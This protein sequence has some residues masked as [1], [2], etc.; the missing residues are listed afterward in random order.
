MSFTQYA[1]V[2]NET[3][4]DEQG[5]DDNDAAT[6]FENADADPAFLRRPY[7]NLS[8]KLERKGKRVINENKRLEEQKR[9]IAVQQAELVELEAVVDSTAAEI[10]ATLHADRQD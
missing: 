1:E 5:E 4:D 10:D 3:E 9:A 6:Q 7:T 2:G 8:R